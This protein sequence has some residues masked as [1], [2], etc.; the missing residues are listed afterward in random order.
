VFAWLAGWFREWTPSTVEDF[1]RCAPPPVAVEPA[2]TS[3][4]ARGTGALTTGLTHT[5]ADRSGPATGVG[6]G[7]AGRL[8]DQA[9][10]LGLAGVGI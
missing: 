10:L 6:R 2:A 8:A 3:L 7:D 4:R 1:A 9:P 5:A